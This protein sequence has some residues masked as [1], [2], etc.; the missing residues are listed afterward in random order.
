VAGELWIGGAGVAAGY[1]GDPEQTG[2]RFLERDG[3]RWYRTGDLGRYWPDGTLEFLGRRDQQVKLRGHRIELGEIEAALEAHPDVTDA[4]A[5]AVDEATRRLVAVV[6]PGDPSLEPP[7][8][9]S[10]LADRLPAYM[11]PE[12]ILFLEEL[13]LTPNG[14]VDRAELQRIALAGS[15]DAVAAPPR[16]PLEAAVAAVW[17]E[18]LERDAVGR[19]ENF[20]ALGG[21]S[22]V[23]TRLVEALRQRFGVDLSLRRLFATP[24]VA[25]LAALVEAERE[26]VAA[27]AVEEGVI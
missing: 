9:R 25:E 11:L 2:E 8:L 12:Q 22:L 19:D 16:G 4:V 24:T 20:F 15:V 1:C 14:K 7:E 27:G 17:K 21:D 18:L 10:F 3:E 26:A 5:L 6:V 13:P 23:A